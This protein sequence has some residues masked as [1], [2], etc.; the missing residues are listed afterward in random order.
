MFKYHLISFFLI[1][2]SAVP[3]SPAVPFK[4]FLVVWNV[5]QG[6]WL[7]RIDAVGCHHFDMGG[8]KNPLPRVRRLCRD[9]ENFIHLSH[10]DWDHVSFALKARKAL[11]RACLRLPPLGKS[12]AYKM[13]ILKAFPP[14]QTSPADFQ[15]L[16]SWRTTELPKKSN[17]LSHVL[18]VAKAW[19]IPGDSSR[20]QEKIW[21]EHRLLVHARALVLGHH[22][23]R[24]ST[25]ETLLQK[26]PFLKF[27]I[28]SARSERYGHPHEEVR[29][30]LRKHRVPLLTTEDWG[31]L[32]FAE[33]D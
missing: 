32:W 1:F 15:E 22:G 19:L 2:L 11:P 16:T 26:L 9:K 4:S 33:S 13:K 7:T 14:C 29:Q 6:Q 10:W 30:R 27:A 20:S 23:S 21:S 12:S 5:G 24:T 31:H 28:A 18:L 25:S 3:I 8:E 17:D